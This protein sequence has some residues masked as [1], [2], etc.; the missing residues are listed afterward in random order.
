M[1]IIMIDPESGAGT[2]QKEFMVDSVQRIK[3]H[4]NI[5]QV[6]FKQG[7]QAVCRHMYA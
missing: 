6:S 4:E 2:A 3:C 1:T 5:P 7:L